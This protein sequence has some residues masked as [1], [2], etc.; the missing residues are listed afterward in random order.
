MVHLAF[1]QFVGHLRSA[2]H[3]LYDPDELRRSPLVRS[4][5]VAAGFD[6]ASAL[7]RIL[8][9]AVEALQP[10]ADEPPQIAAPGAST[11]RW[12]TAMSVNSTAM[13]WQTSSASVDGNSAASSA[14]RW[15]SWQTDSGG[16][17]ILPRRHRLQP[18]RKPPAQTTLAADQG[19]VARLAPDLPAREACR[20]EPGAAGD[21]RPRLAARAPLA[22]A[23]GMQLPRR[24]LAAWLC[25]RWCCV[26]PC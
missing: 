20:V 16:S 19:V 17:A 15:R 12:C 10:G 8:I 11:M 21:P 13:W 25:R 6:A 18:R 4:F 7:Q 9:D 26:T 1:D 3:H 24:R 23:A 2:L 5:G 14:P 22:G